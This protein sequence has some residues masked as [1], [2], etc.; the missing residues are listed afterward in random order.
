MNVRKLLVYAGLAFAA[1]DLAGT[2]LAI[3]AVEGTVKAR[4]DDCRAAEVLRGRVRHRVAQ[5]RRELPATLALLHVKET[6]AVRARSEANFA[7]QLASVQPVDCESYAHKSL[8]W[9]L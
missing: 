9:P 5:E 3:F 4:R 2:P 7:G 6:P 1:L 8:P